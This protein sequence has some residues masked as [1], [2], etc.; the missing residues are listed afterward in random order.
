DAAS[1]YV[2][3]LTGNNYENRQLDF[4]A[5]IGT[6]LFAL[7]AGDVD[8]VF[9]YERREEEADF[10]PLPANQQG[11]TGTGAVQVPRSGEYDTNEFSFE[12]L[13]P[14]LGGDAALP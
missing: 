8:A 5:M 11:L 7:P 12:V 9:A 1:Q 6:S 2:S 14:L 10:V 3:V 13:V 4:L